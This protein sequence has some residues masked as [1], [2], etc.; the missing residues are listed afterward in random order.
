M[1]ALQRHPF[2]EIFGDMPDEE[3]QALKQDICVNGYQN[4]DIILYEGKI[5]DGWHR[6]RVYR[7]TDIDAEFDGG[8]NFVEFDG[9]SAL[10]YVTSA[11]MH[12]RH[13]TPAQRAVIALET[14]KTLEHGTNRF[15]KKVDTP[16]GVSTETPKSLPEVAQEAGVSP[17]TVDRAKCAIKIAPERIDEMK[18][19]TVTPTQIIKQHQKEQE[20]PEPVA[21]SQPTHEDEAA[22]NEWFE[23][24]SKD[25]WFEITGKHPDYGHDSFDIIDQHVLD[26]E[27]AFEE[28]YIPKA[29]RDPQPLFQPLPDKEYDVIY[30]D[31]PWDYKGQKQHTG[32]EGM[33]ESG[34][35][36][37]H[38]P[39]VTL[40][41]LKSLDVQSIVKEDALLFMWAT[42]PHLDQAIELG[43]AW[44]FD[45]KTVAF[46]WDKQVL[47]PGSYTLSQ[48]EFVLVFKH[49]KRPVDP[50]R[51]LNQR[52]FLS[53]E[54]TEHS[55]KPDE[56]RDRIFLMYPNAQ[57]IEL[58]ARGIV[59]GWDAWGNEV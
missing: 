44:G 18:A 49:G 30:A 27:R 6:Y 53:K 47:N 12:R 46:V 23:A 31:P 15:E 26:F 35:A 3:Y 50:H 58:F 55:V 45:Y 14:T 51:Q 37:E 33:R 41:D 5:L 24:L 25:E 19:G 59:E 42:S 39:T 2:S 54:R 36:I 13:L 11:N 28:G 1:T 17:R 52:Q 38:Y 4:P 20:T 34:G 43:E 21:N 8:L 40:E 22:Y 10:A 32:A 16:R 9:E 57:R 56:I 29:K 7:E 48:C